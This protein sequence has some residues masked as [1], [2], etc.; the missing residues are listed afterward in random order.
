M[1][2]AKGLFGCIGGFRWRTHRSKSFCFHGA[3]GAVLVAQQD[4]GAE[5]DGMA[6]PPQ[7]IPQRPSRRTDF[8][9]TSF[10]FPPSSHPARADQPS[11]PEARGEK[12][13]AYLGLDVGSISTNLVVIDKEK[14]VLAKR[15]LMTA[16]RPIEAVRVGLQRSVRRS[17]T[18]WRFRGLGRRAP[19][20]T[21]RQILWEQIWCGMRSLPRPP[22]P[23]IL[24]QK[25]IPSLRSAGK[26]RSISASITGGR[27]F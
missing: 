8:I 17:E 7:S 14:R 24:I 26:T 9:K 2:D 5:G 16:G 19:A 21:S 3:I 4:A 18:A 22:Q 25:W 20:V 1:R 15:Y 10:S 6:Q 27:R 12:I 23:S 11:L 13:E